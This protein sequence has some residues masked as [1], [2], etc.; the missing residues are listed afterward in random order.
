MR[1]LRRRNYVCIKRLFETRNL[2]GA[3]RKLLI[4][5]CTSVCDNLGIMRGW[6]RASIF[7]LG[8]AKVKIEFLCTLLNIHNDSTSFSIL[9]P[10]AATCRLQLCFDSYQQVLLAASTPLAPR[11]LVEKRIERCQDLRLICVRL[12]DRSH[13]LSCVFSPTNVALAIYRK[14]K[15]NDLR[16]LVVREL[17]IL[18]FR[19]RT[20]L[21][22]KD[23]Q[24]KWTASASNN[25]GGPLRNPR[26]KNYVLSSD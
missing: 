26:F 25:R 19:F 6:R 18:E 24:P 8:V 21:D 3:I 4:R 13:V 7:S 1:K 11:I 9:Q 14:M 15:F 2:I 16:Q 17:F 12:Q 10:P 23:E 20:T 22:P 5:W